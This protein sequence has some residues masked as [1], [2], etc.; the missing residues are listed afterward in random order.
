MST[1]SIYFSDKFINILTIYCDNRRSKRTA[2]EYWSVCR[3]ICDFLQKD[4]LEI[5]R[6][7]A[8]KYFDYLEEECQKGNIKDTTINHRFYVCK[9]VAMQ[10]NNISPE[11]G[12]GQPFSYFS[13]LEID[14]E[15][16][17]NKLASTKDIDKLLIA[18]EDNLKMYLMISLA[19]RMALSTSEVANIKED[20]FTYTDGE[21]YLTVTSDAIG[22]D[23]KLLRVPED[24]EILIN[25][26][27]SV[28]E[29]ADE[30][31]YLF[32][33]RVKKKITVR[34]IDSM[35]MGVVARAGLKTRYTFK[36]LR[37]KAIVDTLKSNDDKLETLQEIGEYTGLKG[38]QLN[39]Y[40]EVSRKIRSSRVN[41][42]THIKVNGRNEYEDGMFDVL[43][44]LVGDG[45]ITSKK[46]AE[47]AGVTEEYFEKKLKH[48]RRKS[49]G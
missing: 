28:R 30:N 20:D 31:R 26:Y 7:D 29:Y 11:L 9:S 37:A 24:I 38:L 34:N 16:K 3:I 5:S 27:L 43:F 35:F 6:E 4:F 42:Y 40:I 19:Y 25:K 49:T 21:L 1:P 15:L 14:P 45:T 13:S 8:K 23:Y 2:K 48:Y 12:F 44:K 32:Y 47:T 18:C 10:V 39:K 22:A 46:A 36:D 33:N 41:N 17:A